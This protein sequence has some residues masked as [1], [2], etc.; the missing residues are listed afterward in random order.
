M[1]SLKVKNSESAL[2]AKAQLPLRT[3]SF[4][5]ITEFTTTWHFLLYWSL[6]HKAVSSANVDIWPILSSAE[7]PVCYRLSTHCAKE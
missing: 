4:I 2:L 6:S 3:S 5:L 1:I 7:S